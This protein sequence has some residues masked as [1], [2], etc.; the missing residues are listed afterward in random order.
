[1]V[2]MRT[3]EIRLLDSTPATGLERHGRQSRCYA[4]PLQSLDYLSE[5]VVLLAKSESSMQAIS[6][7][8]TGLKR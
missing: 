1:M 4:A 6:C 7:L 5:S 8:L 2:D 3:I